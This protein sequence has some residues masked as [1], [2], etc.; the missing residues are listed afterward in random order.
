MPGKIDLS[1]V[2]KGTALYPPSDDGGE[3]RIGSKAD[4]LTVNATRPL[5]APEQTNAEANFNVC[6]GLK[7]DDLCLTEPRP[8]QGGGPGVRVPKNGQGLCAGRPGP[9]PRLRIA[10]F[11]RLKEINAG[12]G[13][14]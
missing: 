6:V 2:R 13:T 12:K 4:A 9:I 5:H 7:A 3:F 1:V 8:L 10:L 11:P 14:E